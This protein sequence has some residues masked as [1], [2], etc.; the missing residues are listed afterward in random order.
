M[1]QT[2]SL[3]NSVTSS[4]C[5]EKQPKFDRATYTLAT[6]ASFTM[7]INP[8]HL[9]NIVKDILPRPRGGSITVAERGIC[10]GST[11]TVATA[12]Q[13]LP[14]CIAPACNRN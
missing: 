11:G 13:C 6:R 3:C 14:W 5:I 4:I 2:F 7:E 1:A 12:M 8:D 9:Y 10:S